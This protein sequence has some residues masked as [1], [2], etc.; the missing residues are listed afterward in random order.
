[1]RRTRLCQPINADVL[2]VGV[3]IAKT[4]QVAVATSADGRKRKPLRFKCDAKGFAALVAYVEDQLKRLGGTTWVVALE[5]TGHYAL[6]L[7]SWLV[8]RSIAVYSV[9]PQHTNRAKELYDG[10]SRKT[11]AKDAAV[12]AALCRQGLARAYRVPRGAFAELRVLGKQ[13]QQLVIRRSQ[14]VNRLHRPLDVIF[15]ELRNV[16]VDLLGTAAGGPPEGQSGPRA[17]RT[18][19]PAP[20]GRRHLRG[21]H[22][23]HREPPARDRTAARRAH[24]RPRADPGCGRADAAAAPASAV[25]GAPPDGAAAGAR[26]DR[27]VARGVWRPA[28]LQGR[29]PTR[30]DGG[31]GPRGAELGRAQGPAAH[32]PPR[33]RLWTAVL[34]MA[35]LRIGSGFLSEVRRRAVEGRKAQPTKVA[36]ANMARL[37]RSLHA[38][39]RDLK[40]FDATR[41]ESAEA[42][43][44]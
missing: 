12:I 14:V 15:P 36:V 32:E 16:F 9:Q 11:D 21:H 31:P 4:E 35:A 13:R 38:L 2:I 26:D 17:D 41:F 6:P 43:A 3:D 29:S 1:V 5:P 30:E 10:T 39:A 40:D 24:V 34:Y 18:G 25:R 27:D 7:V 23:G 37:L 42:K 33:A 19:E 44:A 20:G 22:R 8:G 28:G